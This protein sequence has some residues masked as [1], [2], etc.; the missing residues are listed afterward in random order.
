MQKSPEQRI[1]IVEQY[2][3]TVSRISVRRGFA[4]QFRENIDVKTEDRVMEKWRRKGSILNQNKGNSGPKRSVRTDENIS[5][6]KARIQKSSQSVRK[7]AAELGINRESVRII[8]E[9]GQG[10][11]SYKFQTSQQLSLSAG[12]RERRLEFCNRIKRMV[13]QREI[14]IGTII[15]SDES[16]IYLRGF[17]NKQ[18]SESGVEP[19]LKKFTKNLYILQR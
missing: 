11:K 12:D 17:M 1:F 18:I 15:F 3:L 5:S 19:N 10:L 13:E 4:N 16:Y 8:L 2:I 9:K 6:V 14:D 7:I